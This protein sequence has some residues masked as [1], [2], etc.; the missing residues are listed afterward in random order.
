MR[1]LF[2]VLAIIFT[3]IGIAFTIFPMGTMAILPMGVAL[4]FALLAFFKSEE[5]YLDHRN[6]ILTTARSTKCLG[7]MDQI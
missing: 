4:I 1:K 2:I 5:D 3:I 7:L 6:R